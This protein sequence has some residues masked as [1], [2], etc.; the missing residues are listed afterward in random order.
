MAAL[1]IVGATRA[2][3]ETIFVDAAADTQQ[4][5]SLRAAILSANYDLNYGMCA[6][7]DGDDLILLPG[8]TTYP[9]TQAALSVGEEE[10]NGFRGDLDVRGV[11]GTLTIASPARAVVTAAQLPLDKPDRV[12]DVQPGATLVLSGVS[13]RGGLIFGPGGGIR[14]RGSLAM[15]NGDISGN[16]VAGP[17]AGGGIWSSAPADAAVS[18]TNVTIS[19]N[20]AKGDGG[21]IAMDAPG[22]AFTLNHVTVTRNIADGEAQP[23]D[24]VGDGGGVAAAA[25][26]ISVA[27]SIVTGNSDRS[28][29]P[30]PVEANCVGSLASLGHSLVGPGCAGYAAGPGDL[31]PETDPLLGPLLDNGDRSYTHALGAGSPA[32][33]RGGVG[34]P[35]TDQRS[36]RRPL[37]AACDLGAYEAPPVTTPKRPAGDR[38]RAL[39]KCKAKHSKKTKKSRAKLRKCKRKAMKLPL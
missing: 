17:F 29:S 16:I 19:G 7:G 11:Q 22:H 10:D 35:A 15:E 31:L 39:K 32:I 30:S 3:A 23:T 33:D 12:F 14:N 37:G 9:L 28:V 38:A 8:G 5:C 25:G 24:G 27:N 2:V 34:C 18:L 20:L 21:G 26:S 36:I 4:K 6:P 1:G 13:V